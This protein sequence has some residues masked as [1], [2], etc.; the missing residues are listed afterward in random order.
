M[1]RSPRLTAAT[2]FRG[3]RFGLSCL[4]T[5]NRSTAPGLWLSSSWWP[6]SSRSIRNATPARSSAGRC[7]RARPGA[8]RRSVAAARRRRTISRFGRSGDRGSAGPPRRRSR[9]RGSGRR[10]ASSGPWRRRSSSAIRHRDV[11]AAVGAASGRAQGKLAGV[12]E[13]GEDLKLGDRRRGVAAAVGAA[14]SRA[15][16]RARQR[17]PDRRGPR[18]VLLLDQ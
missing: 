8:R 12:D 7:R 3:R 13:V 2:A 6:P 9:A 16:G 5:L 1:R 4:A 10:S 15:Q 17:R 14:N 11:A 18:A